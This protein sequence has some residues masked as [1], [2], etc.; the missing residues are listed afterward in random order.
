MIKRIGLIVIF[1]IAFSAMFLRTPIEKDVEGRYVTWEQYRDLCSQPQWDK[2]NIAHAQL[3]CA[4][5]KHSVVEW[6]GTVKKIVIKATHNQAEE[7][8]NYFPLAVSDWIKCAYGE[9]YP[10]CDT[11]SD[12]NERD[13]CNLATLQGHHTCHIHNLDIYVF[14]IW[15]QMPLENG[16]V[17]DVRI[18]ASNWFKTELM[19][20]STGDN[21]KVRAALKVNLGNTWPEL[22]LY[23]VSC[24]EK[25]VDYGSKST[26]SETSW[27]VLEQV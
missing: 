19:K 25:E 22:K 23:H 5:L 20:L 14:E 11:L 15:L 13:L 8:L 7:F 2:T 12:K 9:R 10:Q 17:H 26:L 16:V 1:T 4:H 21:L 27:R 24:V 18:E 3:R 6:Q